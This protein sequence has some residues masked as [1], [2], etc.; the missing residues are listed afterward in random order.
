MLIFFF[1]QNQDVCVVIHLPDTSYKNL[2]DCDIMFGRN[3]VYILQGFRRVLKSLQ[4]K[5]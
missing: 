2:K 4:S 1:N 3:T 5:I